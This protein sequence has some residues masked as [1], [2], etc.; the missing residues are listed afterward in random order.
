MTINILRKVAAATKRTRPFRILRCD[1]MALCREWFSR[2]G[3]S[4]VETHRNV[5]NGTMFNRASEFFHF[6]S[7]SDKIETR[8]EFESGSLIVPLLL[9]SD[10][11][12]MSG[13]K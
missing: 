4:V 12:R 7:Y 6:Q 10:G 13:I 9:N 11:F 5:H 1:T 2:Y 3:G 8:D